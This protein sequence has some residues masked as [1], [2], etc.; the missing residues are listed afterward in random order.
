MNNRYWENKTLAQMNAAE[1]DA[2]CDGCAL[3]CINK[4]EDVDDGQL[5]YTNTACELLDLDTCR[6]SDYANRAKKVATCLQLT[7]DNVERYD[8][9][10]KSCA[11][12]RLANG[13]P[14]PDWHPLLTG[15]AETVHEAGI[16]L[17][18]ELVQDENDPLYNV[19]Q[20]LE[21]EDHS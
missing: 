16:S 10:P 13:K 5:Y 4:I 21:P 11:Y 12:R 6:C 1:W 9:L 20:L 3:C 18:G 17:L 2:L 19:F 15:R 7:V 8:W 14:L